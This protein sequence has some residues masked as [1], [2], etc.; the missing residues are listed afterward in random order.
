M[1]ACGN[2]ASAPDAAAIDASSG[3]DSAVA[4]CA[5]DHVERINRENDVAAG[6]EVEPTGLEL[7]AS[8]PTATICGELATAEPADVDY[9]LF[10][11]IG[12]D[13]VPLRVELRA[14]GEDASVDVQLFRVLATGGIGL[15]GAGRL[16]GG[17]AV[18]ATGPVAPGNYVL[19]VSARQQ[20]AATLGY[21]LSILE[22]DRRCAREP[23]MAADG[24]TEEGDAASR[25]NDTVEISFLPTARFALTAAADA[26]EMLGVLPEGQRAQFSGASADLAPDGDDYRDRDTFELTTDATTGEL[27][28]RLSWT[29][30]S[31]APDLD[32]FVFSDGQPDDELSFGFGSLA[33]GTSDELVTLTVLPDTTYWIWVGAFAGA[34][35]ELPEPYELTICPRAVAP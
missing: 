30:D 35:G 16:R 9:Y 33:G 18:I 11:V 24:E 8:D 26:P 2:S 32:L 25:A 3:L 14:A 23:L 27:E 5:A 6:G 12:D 31:A 1:A 13:S 28:I 19:S 22:N 20:P 34:G 15:A 17:V 29:H 4:A 10:G 7:P 21:T